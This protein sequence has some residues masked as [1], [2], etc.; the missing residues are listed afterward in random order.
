MA[1][2]EGPGGLVEN[3]QMTE[4]PARYTVSFV[5]HLALILIAI[6]ESRAFSFF[7]IQA[8]QKKQSKRSRGVLMKEV[9]SNTNAIY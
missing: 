1:Y 3:A 6:A 8:K 2:C 7:I 9:L 5:P 4:V